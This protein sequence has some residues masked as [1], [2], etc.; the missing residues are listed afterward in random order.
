MTTSV[1]A[2]GTRRKRAKKVSPDS[3]PPSPYTLSAAFSKGDLFTKCSAVV[4]G[5][6]NIARRQ[7]VKGALFLIVELAFI[8][9]LVR[10]G[11]SCLAGLSD[12][13]PV[14]EATQRW[15]ENGNFV[16]L[17][18]TNSVEVLLY[19]IAW[20]LLIIAFVAFWAA[21]VKSAYK[22][23]VLAVKGKAPGIRQDLRDLVDSRI[24]VTLMS[25]PTLGLLLFTVLPL[26]FMISMAFTSFD[27]THTPAFNWVGL[28]NFVTVLSP[29]S[30]TVGV[31]L[32]LF[33]QVLAW[34]LVWAFLATFLNF[35]LGMFMSMIIL[36]KGTRLKSL[37]RTLFSMSIAVPQFVSLLVINQMLR[38]QGIINQM[39][40]NWGM[41]DA[42]LPFLTNAWWARATVIIVNLWIGI[43]YT[44][45]QITGILQNIPSDLY[46][47]SRIDG[48]SMRQSF[49]Y[50]TMPYIFFVMTPYLI[51]TFTANVNN[52]NVIYL[53][54]NGAPVPVG[55]SAGKTDLLITWLYKLT[56]DKGNFNVGA[57]IGIL[58]F[59]VLGVVSL[60]TY[61][62]SG[63]YRNEEGFR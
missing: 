27:Q 28:R 42:S 58:T 47:A 59:I 8:F 53:L 20:I 50:I 30:N 31:N 26:I 29:G 4:L 45:M 62:S 40:K 60:I 52:F 55:D 54:T 12:L 63:S 51:T 2:P 56:V 19:G 57:V 6:G 1:A 22:V 14:T 10:N 35:F 18:P 23:Q 38:D 7:F 34:T 37:W 49:I 9:F 13:G 61:R 41:I 3:I 5:L 39:L 24:Q 43:P 17:N 48:A 36:R 16:N 25:L 32:S 44:I 11:I 15:D 33:G 21:G 46:E